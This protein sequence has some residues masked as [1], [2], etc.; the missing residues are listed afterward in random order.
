MAYEIHETEYFEKKFHKII[1]KNLQPQF[2]KQ[3]VKA[4]EDPLHKGKPLGDKYFRE[5]KIRG[6]RLYYFVCENE[7]IMLL[8]NVS[9]KKLQQKVINTIKKDMM[10]LREYIKKIKKY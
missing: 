1:P 3:M 7:I 6:F 9:N 5:I 4:S 8:I 10:N 2:R